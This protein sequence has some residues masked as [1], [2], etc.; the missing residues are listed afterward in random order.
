M[1][2][3][4]G[5]DELVRRFYARLWNAWDDDAVD[6]VLAADFA[7]RGSLGEQTAG[8]E[9]WRAYRDLVRRGAP[10][11]THQVVELLVEADSGAEQHAAPR[12]CYTG[13][14]R[15]LLL[16][17]PATGRPFRYDGAA[18]FRARSGRLVAAWVLGDL[19]AL[20]DQLTG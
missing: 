7:F 20:R 1:T 2:A 15:G 5:I 18:F 19:V 16:G 11:F 14:H 6:D 3:P 13:T 12:L 9:G 8:L 10:V 4:P 17:I